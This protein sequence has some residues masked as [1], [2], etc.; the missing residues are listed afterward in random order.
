MSKF[1][2]AKNLEMLSEEHDKKRCSTES[3]V[4]DPLSEKQIAE[5]L[6]K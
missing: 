6:E 5:E 2:A 3:V 4:L 1:K